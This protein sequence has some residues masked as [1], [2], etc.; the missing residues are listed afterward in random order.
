MKQ[1]DVVTSVVASVSR[2]GVT[3]VSGGMGTSTML[4]SS[5]H[6]A[7]T[8]SVVESRVMAAST[9]AIQQREQSR[10][11][12]LRAASGLR[13]SIGPTSHSQVV[14]TTTSAV[15]SGLALEETENSLSSSQI[16][17]GSIAPSAEGYI[18]P[19]HPDAQYA[20]VFPPEMSLSQ[21][22][23]DYRLDPEE[24]W[25]FIVSFHRTRCMMSKN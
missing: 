17:V 8:P 5:T 4:V 15:V 1:L 21:Q 6:I 23:V 18:W 12:A 11:D 14:V 22:N 13:K 10:M 9:D 24:G 20:D 3:T 19:G 25:R 2:S 7:P 16:P